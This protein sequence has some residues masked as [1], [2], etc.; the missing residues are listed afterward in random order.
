V[1]TH[2]VTP[3][4]LERREGKM[5]RRK[6]KRSQQRMIPSNGKIFLQKAKK[7]LR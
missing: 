1:G 4:L 6:S 7:S 3:S 2:S 5:Q